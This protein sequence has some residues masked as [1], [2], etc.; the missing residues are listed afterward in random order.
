M[1]ILVTGGAGFIGSHVCKALAKAGHVPVV[2]DNLSRGYAHAVRWGV[3]ERG[4]LQ[5]QNRLIEVM[6]THKIE[7][8]I[9]L[10]ALAYVGESVSQPD[11][12]YQNNVLG[13]YTLLQAMRMCKVRRLVFSS[14]CAT[15]G[16][17]QKQPIDTDCPQSPINPYG[18]TKLICEQMIEDFVQ[19]FE[20]GSVI[21][22]YFN[23]A[24]ADPDG[25]I[26]ENHEPETHLLP[27]A[28]Q[29]AAGLRTQLDVYGADYPTIDG[30]CVRDYIHVSDLAAGHVLAIDR[31]QLNAVLKCNLGL[32]RGYSVNEVLDCAQR[33][34]GR[35]IARS[36]VARRAGDPPILI[37]DPR[38]AHQLLD[39][40]PKHMELAVMVEH[41]WRW[42]T[43]T[44]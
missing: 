21:L 40:Q 18:R 28:L 44:D 31:C 41:A 3:L 7:A 17:P 22:R 13:T 34:T 27:I 42:L 26:G 9:H 15:Y 30:T 39:W 37:C 1:Q 38:S 16:L 24:G 2:F 10:A 25:E 36:Y 6:Q 5:D 14:S 35:T 12:Y 43:R 8:V 4:D 11:L 19:S 23:A 33:I 20:M 32:G 29:V